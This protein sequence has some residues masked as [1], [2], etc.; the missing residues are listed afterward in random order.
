MKLAHNLEGVILDEK[1]RVVDKIIKSKNQTG[2]WFSV[3]YNVE[4]CKT[5][6]K[7]FLKAVDFS[8]INMEKDFMQEL[9]DITKAY[10]FERDVL[11]VCKNSN[12]DKIVIAKDN[13]QYSKDGYTFPVSYLVFELAKGDIRRFI[14]TSADIDL[15]LILKSLHDTTV[16]LSQLH[17]KDI[18]HQ[19]LKPSNILIYENV[20]SKIGDLG[21]AG[22]LGHSPPHENCTFAGDRAYAPLEQLYGYLHPDWNTRRKGGD[23]YGLGNLVYYYFMD[24]T[25]TNAVLKNLPEAFMFT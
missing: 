21:R 19:D 24:I 14:T 4:N 17:S 20:Q 6:E 22:M 1:W 25:I 5:K 11:D 8:K 23:L 12:L 9:R 16:G 3:C 18:V 2:G 10:I 7:A 13:G 15:S